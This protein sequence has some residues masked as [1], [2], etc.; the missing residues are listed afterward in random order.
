MQT[1]KLAFATEPSPRTYRLRLARYQGLGEA[2][3]EFVRSRRDPASK[4]QLLDV[5]VGNGRTLRYCD[6]HGVGHRIA[7]HGVD[8][9]PRRL[10]AVFGGDRWELK[11]ADVSQGLPYP[12]GRFDIVVCEQLLEHVPNADAVARELIRVLKSGGLLVVGVPIFRPL[13]AFVRKNLVP[14]IDRVFGIRRDH[15]QAFT[16]RSICKLLTNA[17]NVTI[18]KKRGFR[19]MSGGPLR[20]LEDSLRWYQ[21]QRMLGR[22]L[23]SFCVEAQVLATKI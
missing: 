8:N 20:F 16:L 19:L 10:G 2:L 23:P 4:L 21:F 13:F 3:A 15:V 1:T 14:K 18:D 17:G 9:S 6:T 22:M 7:F 12:D 11:Q 5:G